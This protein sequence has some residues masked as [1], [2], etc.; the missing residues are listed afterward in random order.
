MSCL[1]RMFTVTYTLV[2][3]YVDLY[4]TLY[5]YTIL[6]IVLVTDVMRERRGEEGGEG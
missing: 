2:C 5:M 3:I 1:L 4:N 6:G